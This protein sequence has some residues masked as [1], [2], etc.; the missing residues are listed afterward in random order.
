ELM[1][2]KSGL[3]EIID[4]HGRRFNFDIVYAIILLIGLTGFVTDQFLSWLRPKLFPWAEENQKSGSFFSSFSGI[5]NLFKRSE[6]KAPVAIKAA[7]A[8]QTAD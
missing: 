4:T 7:S 3:T 2:V 1:G 6:E 5:S 8:A